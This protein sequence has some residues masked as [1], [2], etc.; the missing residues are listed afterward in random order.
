MKKQKINYSLPTVFGVIAGVTTFT[1][2]KSEVPLKAQ[3]IPYVVYAFVLLVFF[4][5]QI[6]KHYYKWINLFSSLS[7]I[8]LLTVF[9]MF[10]LFCLFPADGMVP[11][12]WGILTTTKLVSLNASIAIIASLTMASVLY[13]MP[14]RKHNGTLQEP[15]TS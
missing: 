13:I 12:Q 11:G 2:V 8:S 4:A 7:K 15:R 10:I 3:F 1:L 9:T 14:F 5:K 6:Q